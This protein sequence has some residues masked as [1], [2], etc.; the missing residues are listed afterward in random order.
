M[1]AAVVALLA[2][3]AAF[4]AEVEFNR[5]VRPILSDRC[6]ACHGPDAANR[7]AN[8]RLDTQEGA[9]RVIVPGQPESSKLIQR[10]MSQNKALRM[11]PAYAGHGPLTEREIATLR[12]WIAQGARWEK[13]WAFLPP[14]KRPLPSV[15]HRSWPR[16][17]LDYFI[18]ARLEREGL[19]PS[20]EAAKAR[21]LRR[22]TLDLTGLP[23]TVDELEAF[24]KDERPDAYERLVDRLLASPRFA[25]R[26]GIRWLEAARYA[27]THGYQADGPRDMWRWRDWVL[28]SFH[29]NKPFDRFVMEQIA[30]DLL[31][32]ATRDQLI[33]TGFHRNHRT[34]GEGGIIEEEFRTEYVADRVETTSTVFLGLTVGCARCHDHKYD[35]MT[36]RDYYRLFAFFNN[37]PDRGLVYNFGNE[38]PVIK[39]PTPEQEKKLAELDALAD[40]ETRQWQTAQQQLG[41]E[42]QKWEKRI[43]GKKLDWQ[44]SEG[45]VFHA[46]LED[47]RGLKLECGSQASELGP[48]EGKVGRAL[49]FA[50]GVHLSAG[51]ET[52]H[53]DYLDPFT[54]AAWIQ[55]ET[56]EGTIVSRSEDYL[57]GEGWGLHL[58]GGKLRLQ[59]TRRFT[60][61][62][63]RVETKDSIALKR[64][65]H[66][67]VTYDGKRYARGVRLYVNGIEQEVHVLFNDLNYPFGP[68]EPLRI[69]AGG[70]PQRRFQGLIDEVRIY[71][72]ALS[73]DEVAA[74]TVTED[75]GQLARRKP[76]ERTPAQQAKLRLAFI[77]RFAP[78]ALRE[79]RGR[80]LAAAAER[81]RY[82]KA[83]PTVMVMQEVPQPRRTFILKRGVY[84]APGEEVKPGTPEVLHPW[85]PEWPLNRLGLAYWL[86]DRSNPLTA[87]VTVNRF[88]QMLFGTGLVKTVEDFGS[89]GEWPLH[90]DLLDWLAVEFMDSG[91]DVKHMFRLM[92]T[93]AGYRQDSRLRPELAERDPENRLLARG[94]RFRLPAEVIRDQALY[95]SGLL[96]ERFGGP[97][98]KPYQPPGLWQEL[99]GGKGY[100]RDT[101]EGLYRRSLYTY[102]KRTVPPPEMAVFDAP[103]R[104]VCTVRE[105]RTNTPLQALNLMNDVGILEASRKLAERALREG[106][107]GAESRIRW[108]YRTVLTREPSARE[109]RVME[110][111]LQRFLGGWRES[112]ERAVEY[113]AIGD[114]PRDGRWDPVETAS[115]TAVANLVLNLDEAVT[116]Q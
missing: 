29:E 28:Q 16:N 88:W 68:K 51:F 74:L 44:V 10:V 59:I 96:V 79:L 103:T 91:W 113:L 41:A 73:A 83:I 58:I 109:I 33:A 84:D 2:A 80:M 105:V 49:R 99:A 1:T 54:L 50:D 17:A 3:G 90:S 37:T 70:G 38:E 111:A 25:E 8:L 20:P 27:D 93:S 52:A 107:A 13:H 100:Q 46:A 77:D 22:V 104:E 81:E 112:K 30:G 60:D 15:K 114:S 115:W 65:S 78:P 66:V 55:P 5:D 6:F 56:G 64:W 24:L 87:R 94:P 12:E 9:R 31:P 86:T 32:A 97:S 92:V 89:Q 82:Y 76:A 48:A 102:W 75:L 101:G 40:H 106:G 34:N 98:V 14:V 69:G 61:I 63:L 116:K 36:Q 71:G 53:F 45:L 95:V 72:R 11:P 26:I 110:D 21:L 39:A 57:E 62:S 35:P 85:K 43:R 19:L 4:A 47:G 18:L 23:P 67:A 42:Q 7:K 108:L